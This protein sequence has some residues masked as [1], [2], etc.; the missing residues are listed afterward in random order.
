MF[1]IQAC[2]RLAGDTPIVNSVKVWRELRTLG[3]QDQGE[4]YRQA[5]ERLAGDTSMPGLWTWGTVSLSI[6]GKNDKY[7]MYIWAAH[8]PTTWTFDWRDLCIRPVNSFKP[9]A[10]HLHVLTYTQCRELW[11]YFLDIPELIPKRL[12]SGVHRGRPP[13]LK[14]KNRHPNMRHPV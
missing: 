3:C 1:L 11:M 2:E 10:G 5:C 6:G 7:K 12:A 9:A 14:R 4:N 8:Q 13:L